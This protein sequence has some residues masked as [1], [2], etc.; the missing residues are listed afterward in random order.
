MGI[1]V[2]QHLGGN[3]DSV[4]MAV[5]IKVEK[6]ALQYECL[7]LRLYIVLVGR[8]SRQDVHSDSLK[9]CQQGSYNTKGGR[10]LRRAVILV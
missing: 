3:I 5:E 8:Y 10:F 2:K 9:T 7:H 4:C 6:H 1:S